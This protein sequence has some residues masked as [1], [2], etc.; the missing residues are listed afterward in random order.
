MGYDVVLI[1][2]LALVNYLFFFSFFVLFM[3]YSVLGEGIVMICA[4][5]FIDRVSQINKVYWHKALY[6]TNIKEWSTN[7]G[8]QFK[9]GQTIT[10][11]VGNLFCPPCSSFNGGQKRLPTLRV[12]VPC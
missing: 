8:Y 4:I 9:T 5:F 1:V 3:V 6:P 11:R 12:F 7:L 2:H 10:R